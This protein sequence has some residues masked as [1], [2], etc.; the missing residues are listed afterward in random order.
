LD[1]EGSWYCSKNGEVEGNGETSVI[2]DEWNVF[3]VKQI[4]WGQMLIEVMFDAA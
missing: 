3:C 4:T 2:I 1:Y